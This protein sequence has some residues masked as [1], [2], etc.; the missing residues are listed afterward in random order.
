MYFFQNYI[1][2]TYW[3]KYKYKN[4]SC[5]LYQVIFSYHTHFSYIYSTK[6]VT[7]LFLN[8]LCSKAMMVQPTKSCQC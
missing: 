5:Q 8:K 3:L 6:R 2:S 4:W 1:R 7:V